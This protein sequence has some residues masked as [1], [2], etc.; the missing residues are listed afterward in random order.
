MARIL[1]LVLY[2]VLSQNDT[3]KALYNWPRCEP[4]GDFI[5]FFKNPNTKHVLGKVLKKCFFE[6]FWTIFWPFF[7]SF[8][9]TKNVHFQSFLTAFCKKKNRFRHKNGTLQRRSIR[10][11]SA[12]KSASSAVRR[13]P[14]PKKSSQIFLFFF[15]WTVNATQDFSAINLRL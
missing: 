6:I 8:E 10:E 13:S 1:E 5:D 7:Y 14:Q 4:Q 15:S 9:I 11:K 3:S 12:N 2:I